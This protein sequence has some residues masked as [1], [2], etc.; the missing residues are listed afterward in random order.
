MKKLVTV[1]GPIGTRS[2]Y[3]SHARDIVIS[4][5]DLGYDVKTMP[6]RWGMTPQNALNI[7]S[8]RDK[9]IV[10]TISFD[11]KIDRQPDIHVHISVP[12]E[13]QKIGKLNIGI[14]AGVE[15]THPNPNWVNAMNRMDYNLVPSNFVKEVMSMTYTDDKKQTIACTKP[16]EVLFEGYDETIYK[17][18]NEYS[19]L[20]VKELDV[21][22]EDFC[23]L[24]VGH[25][26]SGPYGHDRKDVGKLVYNFLDTF[27]DAKDMPALIMKTSTGTFSPVDKY[28]CLD[29]MR[30]IKHSFGSDVKLPKI[31]FVHGEFSDEQMNELYN[32]PKVKS[33]VSFTKGEGYGRPLLEFSTTGKP[34]IATGW[35]GHT[36]FLDGEYSVLLRGRLDKVHNDAVPKDYRHSESQW[37]NVDEEAAKMSLKYVFDNYEQFQTKGYAQ[38]MKSTEFTLTAMTDKFGKMLDEMSKDLPQQVGIKLPT[39]KKA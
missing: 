2:G 16:I 34:V 3:G 22:K 30:E 15:W 20:L 38:K 17:P 23:Y 25:W 31:Y 28:R 14:T 19:E 36:D 9:R 7:N 10:D 35:S 26:L 13:F 12:T 39:L 27:K 24:F 32:H 21:I 8:A 37:F 11:G 5:L 18:V 1:I 4:L 33:M 29:R 6:I